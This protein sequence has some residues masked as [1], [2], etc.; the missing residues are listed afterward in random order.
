MIHTKGE[1]NA[2]KEVEKA[3]RLGLTS[4]KEVNRLQSISQSLRDIVQMTHPQKF[5]IKRGQVVETTNKE[6]EAD[7]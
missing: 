1:L 4:C 3:V 6:K 7:D 5:K 2:L